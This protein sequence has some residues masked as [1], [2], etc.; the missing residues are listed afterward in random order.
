M[1]AFLLTI[2]YSKSHFPIFN[3]IVSIY[4]D[5]N[6]VV[7]LSIVL[8]IYDSV[9]LF[10]VPYLMCIVNCVNA[11][12]LCVPLQ[13]QVSPYIAAV[14]HVRHL[15]ASP[16]LEVMLMFIVV[17]GGVLTCTPAASKDTFPHHVHLIDITVLWL[18]LKFRAH[19]EPP[20]AWGEWEGKQGG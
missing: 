1:G 16:H 7:L 19:L 11:W 5:N 4:E 6:S 18:W 9:C 2:S 10:I 3:I 12:Q 15:N 20:S 13:E 8:F 17:N 14:H